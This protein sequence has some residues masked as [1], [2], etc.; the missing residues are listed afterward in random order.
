MQAY[1]ALNATLTA[2]T[3]VIQSTVTD[4]QNDIRRL[5][6][7]WKD[8]QSEHGRMESLLAQVNEENLTP[9]DD[10]NDSLIARS[11]LRETLSEQL[12]AEEA[13]AERLQRVFYIYILQNQEQKGFI[14]D[15]F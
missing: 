2:E 9:R 11:T 13:L 4:L 15:M 3:A 12:Q 8:L 14:W 1:N 7:T 6:G 5:E 10:H